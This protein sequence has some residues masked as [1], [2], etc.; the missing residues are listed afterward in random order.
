MDSEFFKLGSLLKVSYMK[1]KS[2]T[3]VKI[4]LKNGEFKPHTLHYNLLY[5]YRTYQY[6]KKKNALSVISS[7]LS[8]IILQSYSFRRGT[9]SSTIFSLSFGPSP[10][11]PD[12]VAATS[13]SGTVHIF[14]LGLAVNER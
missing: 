10:Q 9:Y 13:S 12:F 8:P 1:T 6:L 2:V 4:L 5:L 3:K 7:V 14:H 11:L